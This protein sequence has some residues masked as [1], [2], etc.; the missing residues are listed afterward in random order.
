MVRVHVREVRTLILGISSHC[1]LFSDYLQ[2]VLREA[3]ESCCSVSIPRLFE[4]RLE[5]LSREQ[6]FIAPLTAMKQVSFL[7]TKTMAF[8]IL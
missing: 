1:D 3:L 7:S 8:A 2:C 5:L 4:Q 6:T